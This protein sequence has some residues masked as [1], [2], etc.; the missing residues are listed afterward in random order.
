[1]QQQEQIPSSKP[2]VGALS[3]FSFGSSS[4]K[5]LSMP[6]CGVMPFHT[7]TKRYSSSFGL[8]TYSFGNIPLQMQQQNMVPSK[9]PQVNNNNNNNNTIYF[10][11]SS[12]SSSANVSYFAAPTTALPHTTPLPPHPPINPP[13][14]KSSL[15]RK[16]LPLINNSSNIQKQIK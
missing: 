3:S 2:L 11:P 6:L 14:I 13:T 7:T 8:S 16:A 12:S 15:Q 4:Q 1:M 9:A 5:E 10:A